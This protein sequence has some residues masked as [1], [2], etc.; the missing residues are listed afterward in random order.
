M[1]RTKTGRGNKK[2]VCKKRRVRLRQRSAVRPAVAYTAATECLILARLDYLIC[3]LRLGLLTTTTD[4][5][6]KLLI[7]QERE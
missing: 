3:I 5:S 6:S 2:H 1:I 4:D 7:H